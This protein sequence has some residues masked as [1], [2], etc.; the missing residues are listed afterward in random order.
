MVFAGDGYDQAKVGVD[1]EVCRPA[2]R[3]HQ[4]AKLPLVL[5]RKVIASGGKFGFGD[6]P[7]LDGLAKAHLVRF[8]E[9]A[10]APRP[11]EIEAD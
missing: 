8:G 11:F 4:V 6:V 1:E 7:D 3:R 9:Q 10:E 5:G 2:S